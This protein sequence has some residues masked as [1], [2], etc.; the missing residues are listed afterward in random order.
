MHL[1]VTARFA[2]ARQKA[3]LDAA[4]K[5]ICIDPT[6]G[7]AKVGDL[8]GMYGYK[9]R[10]SEQQCLLAYRILNRDSIKLL[11]FGRHENFYRDLK[12]QGD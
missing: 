9:F 12:G 5:R 1:L 7:D 10:L 11:I 8:L 6:I 3:E 4:L 2:R